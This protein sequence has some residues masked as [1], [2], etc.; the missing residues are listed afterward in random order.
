VAQVLVAR[1][2]SR[3]ITAGDEVIDFLQQCFYTRVEVV[4]V[5]DYRD[6]GIAGPSCR[7]RGGG[8]IVAIHV[9]RSGV[10]DPFAVEFFRPQGQS[11][12]ALPQDGTLS[13]VVDQDNCLL[14]GASRG[15]DEMGL[16]AE[17]IKLGAVNGAGCVVTNLTHIAS[18]QTPLLTG[19][20]GGC[21]LSAREEIGGAKFDFGSVRGMVR[22]T[23]Q[24]VGSIQ[25]D[26]DQVNLGQ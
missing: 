11:I 21:D 22:K 7:D 15:G 26:T 8:C 10:D 1:Q 12:V 9:E 3:N 19:G 20:D 16:D 5:G 23:N 2:A 14:A 17:T 24:H 25:S 4:E 18:P 6:A 13:S